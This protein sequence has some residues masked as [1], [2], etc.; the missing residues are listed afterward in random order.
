MRI[1]PAPPVRTKSERALTNAPGSDDC[2][3]R[4]EVRGAAMRGMLT[5]VARLRFWCRMPLRLLAGALALLAVPAVTQAQSKLV[6]TIGQPQSATGNPGVD[7]VVAFTTGSSPSYVSS[8]D[9]Q[10]SSVDPSVSL[11]ASIN[12]VSGGNLGDVV[13][14][15][16]NPDPFVP[17]LN[18][19]TASG[20]GIDLDAN[21]TYFLLLD[22]TTNKTFGLSLTTSF[23]EDSGGAAGWSV[24]DGYHY[25]I[26]D[27]EGLPAWI[28]TTD[29]GLRIQVN[30]SLKLVGNTARTGPAVQAANVDWAQSFTTGSNRPGYELTRAD[31]RM[32]GGSGTAPTYT[33]SIYSDSSSSPGNEVGTL[34]N[35]SAWPG[36]AGLAKHNAPS[37]G[38]DLKANTTYWLVF[39]ITE[40]SN[41][42]T[43]EWL[44]YQVS[45]D[46][47]DPGAATGWSIGNGGRTRTWDATTWGALGADSLLVAVYGNAKPAVTGVSVASTPPA[48]DTYRLGETIQIQLT[49]V[50]AVTVDTSGG[51]PRLKIKMDPTYGEKWAD[52]ASGSGTT[53]RFEYEVVSGNVSTQGIAVLEDTL[54]L[55][56][57]TIKFTASQEDARLEHTGLPH[58][59]AHKV[60]GNLAPLPP[61]PPGGG[62]GGGGSSR[63]RDDHGN[64]AGRA[65]RIQPGGRTAGQFH[66][67]RDVDYFTLTAPHA[68]VVVVETTGSTATRGTVWQDGVEVASADSGGSGQNFRLSVR[69]EAGPVVIA[70][71]GTGRQTGRY[72]LQTALV[73]GHLENPRLASFQSGLGVISGWVCEAEGVTVEIEKADGT[74]VELAAAYGTARADTAD[75]CGD[76][77]TGFGVLVNWNLL[78]DGDHAVRVLVNGVALGVRVVPGFGVVPALVDGLE[79]G[80]A[81]VTVTTLGAEFVKGLAGSVPIEDFPRQGEQV[82]VVWQESQQNF[83]LAPVELGATV[84]PAPSSG[85]IEGVLENPA[86]ASFQSGIGVIS[87]WVCEA[88]EVLIEI[89]GQP[90]AA[91]AGTERADTL[92]RCGDVDNGFG[93]LVNWAEFGAGAHEVVALVDGAELSRATVTVT[94]VDATEPFVRGLTKRV[95][96]PDF[97]TPAETVTLEWQES[98]Q[99]FVIT[100]VD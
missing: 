99:N 74:L 76:S 61:P 71:R 90:I 14:T 12:G 68:G 69:V 79:L 16:T 64:T 49:L 5:S 70:V 88:D 20:S 58:D 11:S 91:A 50:E 28:P 80:R 7:Y 78:G 57:G 26:W 92:D 67:T 3:Q 51:T 9:V 85:A 32:L 4:R 31:I 63:P 82:R 97:P 81:P 47:E 39:D 10:T 96:L 27:R 56:G 48:G 73:V 94:V 30:G 52:Y 22:K 100:G 66:T 29:W 6:G 8:V 38:I 46:D 55:N 44:R 15:L 24:A 35:P 42:S 21:T 43:T 54:E 25:R 87:G 60:N 86:P 2:P 98:Q 45:T 33:A 89:D 65:T 34:T 84:A 53:L 18:T 83:V 23:A 59:S 17:G 13:G 1:H 19:F 77:D 72:T 62:G 41:S 75:V 93:L 95:E 36:S 37:G 40:N